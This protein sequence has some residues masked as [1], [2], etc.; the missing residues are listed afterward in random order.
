VCAVVCAEGE[1]A[2]DKKSATTNLAYK[3][4]QPFFEAQG[5][6]GEDAQRVAAFTR[7]LDE[8]KPPPDPSI[9]GPHMESIRDSL[10]ILD[11]LARSVP[12]CALP[13]LEEVEDFRKNFK[14]QLHYENGQLNHNIA[15]LKDHRF[16]LTAGT[17]S[18]RR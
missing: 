8:T 1:R 4:L 7:A 9:Y 16:L 11:E 2:K 14:W 6:P 18:Y 17:R 3:L 10:S 12:N 15:A 13:T 5:V